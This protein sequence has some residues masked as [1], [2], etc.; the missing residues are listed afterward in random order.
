[1]LMSVVRGVLLVGLTLVGATIPHTAKAKGLEN[2]TG[3]MSLNG[4]C[5]KFIGYDTDAT[6]KCDNKLA[7]TEFSDGRISFSFVSRD[8]NVIMTFEG[9]GKAQIHK[10][11]DTAIQPLSVIFITFDGKTDNLKAVGQC[12]FT[13]P[14][15]GKAKINCSADTPSGL[16]AGSF[17]TDGTDPNIMEI[18]SRKEA[19]TAATPPVTETGEI[20]VDQNLNQCLLSKAQYGE[21]SSYNGGKSAM[22]LMMDCPIEA[23]AWIDNCVK[24]GDEKGNCNL[25]VGMLAQVAIKSFGK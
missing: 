19:P 20:K 4:T 7:H 18:E 3:L 25:K 9:N 14:Y 13:N 24:G 16:F 6:D 22:K 8:G 17:L 21:Y 2:I 11:A 12:L 15:K 5:N 10:D 23:K 1:M